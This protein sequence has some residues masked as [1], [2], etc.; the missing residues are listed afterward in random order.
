MASSTYFNYYFFAY[1]YE[2]KNP[3]PLVLLSSP[4]KIMFNS[5][6]FQCEFCRYQCFCRALSCNQQCSRS[7]QI[8]V[9]MKREKN[10][11]H[12]KQSSC[13]DMKYFLGC[14]SSGLLNSCN[15]GTIIVLGFWRK[16]T[17]VGPRISGKRIH[18]STIKTAEA[19]A[20]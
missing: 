17:M 12:S 8:F 2:L 6:K 15:F 9:A 11:T 10:I 18:Q 19:G 5:R 4:L 13:L 20:D 14:A 3:F 7:F 16:S 1:I